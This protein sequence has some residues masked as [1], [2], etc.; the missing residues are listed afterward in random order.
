MKFK[1][2][3]YQGA[4]G[5]FLLFTEFE[6]HLIALFLCFLHKLISHSPPVT[7]SNVNALKRQLCTWFR[8]HCTW[9]WRTSSRMATSW[10]RLR[11]VNFLRRLL[12]MVRNRPL[13][14]D[15][16]RDINCWSIITFSSSL[17]PGTRRLLFFRGL[18]SISGLL[19]L[20]LS[21]S[22]SQNSSDASI[23]CGWCCSLPDSPRVEA[24]MTNGEEWNSLIVCLNR[25]TRRTRCF[26]FSKVA[27]NGA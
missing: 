21:V 6:T 27:N 19:L 22:L 15:L 4:K 20:L 11:V 26:Q 7:V 1:V 18:A 12:C 23:I 3:I 17:S 16:L 13:Q 8:I 14:V 2:S 24:A 9:P 5:S 25:I 10:S